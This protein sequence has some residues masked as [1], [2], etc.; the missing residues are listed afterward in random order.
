MTD[1]ADGSDRVLQREVAQD[2][3]VLH[4]AQDEIGGSQLQ[5]R[6]GL[7]QVGVANDDVQPR[8]FSASACGSSRVLMIGLE[9]VVADDTPSQMCSARWLRQKTDPR[10][11]CSTLPAPVMSCRVTRNGIKTSATLP[12]SPCRDTR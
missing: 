3:S 4:H 6:R 12:N 7:G 10:G 11:V 9:R 1:L 5:Q 2:H 8:Y